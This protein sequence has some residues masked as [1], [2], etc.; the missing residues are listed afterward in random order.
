MLLIEHKH[1]FIKKNWGFDFTHICKNCGIHV[2]IMD[3]NDKKLFVI[4]YRNNHA[5]LTCDE[6]QIKDIIE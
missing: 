4:T 6:I 2:I 3:G 1:E 5:I